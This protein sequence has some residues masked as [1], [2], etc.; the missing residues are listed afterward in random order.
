MRS[1]EFISRLVW[2]CFRWLT[3]DESNKGQYCIVYDTTRVYTCAGVREQ[4]R[5]LD[6]VSGIYDISQWDISR[7]RARIYVLL[8]TCGI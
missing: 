6:I 5:T 7:K 1:G 2:V 4:N 3:A 8:N